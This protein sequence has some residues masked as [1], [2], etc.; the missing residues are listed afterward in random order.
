MEYTKGLLALV[1]ISLSGL[2]LQA[3][4]FISPEPH[5][6]TWAVND[7]PPFHIL[8]GDYQSQGFC[9][10]LVKEMI[11]AMPDSEHEVLT[12][13]PARIAR[14][15]EKRAPLCFPC[16]IQRPD[17]PITR[18]S[19]ATLY[20]Q[21]HQLIASASSAGLIGQR[22]GQPVDFA[23][24]LQ[25]PSL[26]FGRP[27]GRAYG[28][29]LQ[30]LLDQ[31]S[32][33]QP[34]HRVL[35]GK[36]TLALNMVALGRLDYTLDYPVI[37]RYFELTEKENLYYLPIAQNQNSP[38]IGA[39]GCSNTEWGKR[40]IEKIDTA[41]V[42]VLRSEPYLSSIG[43]WFTKNNPDF[44]QNY[45]EHVLKPIRENDDEKKASLAE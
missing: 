2:T 29:E 44:W 42:E 1:L 17:T 23:A 45:K 3:E 5:K 41:L 22:Y 27:L 16:M 4:P 37:G 20:Y 38:I 32:E 34:N 21:P 6:V 9:D 19:A 10:V 11:Q 14:L 25:D 30:P 26:Q 12:I 7:G 43:F 13:P 36:S 31:F 40:T 39:I 8:D 24:L 18:Y 33:S 15:R 28:D 35:S